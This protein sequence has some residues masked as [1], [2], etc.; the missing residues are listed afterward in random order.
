MEERIK[1]SDRLP[2]MNK[3]VIVCYYGSDL[4]IQQ[5][6]ETLPDAMRR[7]TK[8]ATVTLGWIG[9][10]GWYG[11]DGFP[12]MVT[13]IYWWE[14]PKA[15]ECPRELIEQ[16]VIHGEKLAET[17]KYASAYIKARKAHDLEIKGAA[18]SEEGI[19][20]LVRTP[21]EYDKCFCSECGEQVEKWFKFCPECGKRLERVER[22][23]KTI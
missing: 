14:L 21:V 16:A 2:E 4:I 18:I 6:G 9:E 11:A 19:P 8:R 13:P 1:C 23:D 17:S 10:D 3:T 7:I 20:I 22:N 15:P 12:L 5:N